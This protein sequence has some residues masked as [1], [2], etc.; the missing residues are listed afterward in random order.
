MWKF[1]PI[2]PGTPERN[3]RETE[4]FRL[5]SPSEAVIREFIQNSLDARK[6]KELVTVKIS[7]IDVK[8][9][10]IDD[11]L[12]TTL[13]KHLNACNIFSGSN[14][15]E[16]VPCLVLEDFGTTGLDGAF[17]PDAREGNFYNFWWREGISQKTQRKAGRW[18]LGKITFHIVSKIRTFFGLTVRNDGKILLMGK[19]L[20]KT[21][22]LN[23]KL[24]HYFGYFSENNFMPVENSS[25]VTLFNNKFGINRNSNETGLSL[26]IPFP[27]DEINFDSL[28]RGV[29]QHYFYPILSGSLRVEVHNHGRKEDL[30]DNNLIE[31]VSTIDW[32]NTEWDGINVREVLTAAKNAGNLQ[33]VDLKIHNVG[34]PTIDETSFDTTQLE[35]IK[36]SFR[37]GNLH[38]FRVP[39]RIE[40]SDKKY[41]MSNSSFIIILKRFS[42][43]HKPFEA[44]IRSG[45]LVSEIKMLGS[46][47]VMGIFVAEDDVISE[48]L[49]DC[50][51]PAHTEWNERTEGFKEKYINAARVLRFIKKAMLQVVSILD[52]PPHERQVDF[53]K[54]IFYLPSD[55]DRR[56][57][58]EKTTPPLVIPPIKRSP[59]IFNILT[60]QKGFSITLNPQI[61]SNISFPVNATVKMAY[62]T[63]RGDPFA[64]YTKFDFDVKNNSIKI[65]CKDCNIQSK[66]LNK[67]EIEV[68]GSNFKLEVTGFD[69]RR[70]LVV[71]IKEK[72]GRP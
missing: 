17:T 8:K 10:D 59:S 38:K 9:Q 16:I 28:L 46:R 40:K 67:L 47:P 62:D 72:G 11:F 65:I 24:Y 21:H 57:K 32:S 44:Y 15:S 63:F 19:T 4:F 23:E 12:D 58:E 22:T 29:V 64:R 71:E 54:E 50:E 20:L 33:P 13:E 42:A 61:I 52:E 6:S 60:T 36:D 51:T 53:L 48:F 49:G 27:V 69:P 18:G 70:D 66:N 37:S 43:P 5:R 31:K 1:R 14:F 26:V 7:I 30:N 55:S 34:N 2:E 3:P 41:K 68:T 25:V 39:V 45:I 35:S 56:K